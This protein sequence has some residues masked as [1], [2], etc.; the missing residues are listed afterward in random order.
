MSKIYQTIE[1]DRSD[2]DISKW[3][4]D[5]AINSMKKNDKPKL[6]DGQD[7]RAEDAA[8]IT[9]C[10]RDI[11][12]SDD[13]LFSVERKS[14]V[15][16]GSP[17]QV[18][19]APTPLGTKFLHCLDVNLAYLSM[20]EPI[21]EANP[22]IGLFKRAVDR[23]YE[24]DATAGALLNPARYELRSLSSM[25]CGLFD[26]DVW[27]F[28]YALND[29]VA[30]IRQQGDAKPFRDELKT[31]TRLAV[32]NYRSL[33]ALIR[34][35]FA[36]HRR[37]L[38]IRVDFEYTKLHQS[39]SYADVRKHC[40]A[41]IR[42]LK[43]T[44][45]RQR[46]IFKAYVL[47]LEYAL[48]RGWHFHGLIFLDGHVVHGDVHY[49]KKFGEHWNNVITRLMGGYY[50]CNAKPG[51]Y[52]KHRGI[53]MIESHEVDRRYALEMHVAGYLAK[54]DFYAP[55]MKAD[56][57]R[58]LFKSKMPHI[59]TVKRG[60]RSSKTDASA[61]LDRRPLPVKERSRTSFGNGL[62]RASRTVEPTQWSGRRELMLHA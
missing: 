14:G 51:K 60:R 12:D 53:G 61:V 20:G 48:R 18:K 47:K 42:Y 56:G 9:V 11:I 5:Y 16:F 29:T 40:A 6:S 32:K 13:T 50:N 46:K 27:A 24:Q 7:T 54:P 62:A 59:A 22:F 3:L 4:L 43:R 41:L 44:Q 2:V 45:H 21:D 25:R 30:E 19:L 1:V 38:V 17:R 49:G 10:I 57:E 39:V 33:V 31:H 26:D 8:M 23:N 37:L 34:A 52:G 55:T 58:L 28:A 35:L 36:K 15:A